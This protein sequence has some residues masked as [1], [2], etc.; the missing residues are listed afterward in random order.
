MRKTNYA[1]AEIRGVA[2]CSLLLALD[3]R[4]VVLHVSY[5]PVLS[6]QI[7]RHGAIAF[8][9]ARGCRVLRVHDVKG[10]VRVANTL[11][12]ILTP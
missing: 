5:C 9:V 11:Q 1:G 6:I 3:L 8:G 4:G 12:A 2:V 7:V 10:A